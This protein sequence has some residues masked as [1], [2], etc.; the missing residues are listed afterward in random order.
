MKFSIPMDSN[1]LFGDKTEYS[2]KSR[3]QRRALIR[4]LESCNPAGLHLESVGRFGSADQRLFVG[5]AERSTKGLGLNELERVHGA[6]I[7]KLLSE[8]GALKH[9]APMLLANDPWMFST[10]LGD[11]LTRG[12]AFDN[13]VEAQIA[14]GTRRRTTKDSW[15][16]SGPRRD[17]AA[18]KRDAAMGALL[19]LLDGLEGEE[20][21]LLIRCVLNP[22]ED[23][24]S[25]RRLIESALTAHDSVAG[26]LGLAEI[27]MAHQEPRKAL[28]VLAAATRKG[29]PEQ[30]AWR[31]YAGLARVH[32][33]VGGDRLALQSN[34]IASEKTGCGASPRVAGLYLALACG[35]PSAAGQLAR[36][37]DRS[38]HPAWQ[39]LA[40]RR[41]LIRRLK[42]RG[43]VFPWKPSDSNSN[44]LLVRLAK[45]DEGASALVCR[46]LLGKSAVNS[47]PSVF[48]QPVERGAL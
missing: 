39:L 21:D 1:T 36:E 30:D 26:R 13:E 17:F 33:S 41:D 14:S 42:G 4:V 22:I 44:R 25:A 9:E 46:D 27:H 18:W 28:R 37:L 6:E 10:G 11:F 48:C 23:W 34:L 24:E 19:A 16:E 31:L 20:L 40:C 45:R 5:R 15:T 7:A 3:E 47:I 8:A 38:L 43:V 29:V 35:D 32:E 12:A 2:Y